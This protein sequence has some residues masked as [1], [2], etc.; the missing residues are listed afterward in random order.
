M[1]K[2]K[3]TFSRLNK[4]FGHLADKPVEID[5]AINSDFNVQQQ[6]HIYS[7]DRYMK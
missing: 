7:N 1:T 5:R 2:L 4:F 6:K 3:D